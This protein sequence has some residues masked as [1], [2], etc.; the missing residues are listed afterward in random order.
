MLYTWQDTTVDSQSASRLLSTSIAALAGQNCL[1]I[2]IWYAL[3][4]HSTTFG[5]MHACLAQGF[6]VGGCIQTSKSLATTSPWGTKLQ[7]SLFMSQGMT[8]LVIAQTWYECTCTQ[9]NFDTILIHVLDPS[10]ARVQSLAHCRFTRKWLWQWGTKLT[11]NRCSWNMAYSLAQLFLRWSPCQP[12]EHDVTILWDIS[13]TGLSAPKMHTEL[14][15]FRNLNRRKSTFGRIKNRRHAEH[16]CIYFTIGLLR[17]FR[18]SS[19]NAPYGDALIPMVIV[20]PKY[21]PKKRRLWKP[22]SWRCRGTFSI[23]FSF[24]VP[25]VNF[26][27]EQASLQKKPPFPKQG[28]CTYL[29]GS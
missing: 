3:L 1:A 4:H 11:S 6:V 15:L 9:K 14:T 22:K 17:R 18:R 27:G 8:P 13:G 24:Q 26:Q 16:L 21:T 23:R 29:N 7:L 5:D 2:L 28:A 20:L 19:A 10:N 12:K 25:A